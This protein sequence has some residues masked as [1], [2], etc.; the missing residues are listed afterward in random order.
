MIDA[1]R[2]LDPW[3]PKILMIKA[4]IRINTER[5]AEKYMFVSPR[6]LGLSERDAEKYMFVSP[7]F[8]RLSQK[9]RFR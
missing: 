4:G 3:T 2:V 6:F 5:D 7:R 8:S 1:V 9:V